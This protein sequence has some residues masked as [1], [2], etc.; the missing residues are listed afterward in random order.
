VAE[1]GPRRLSLILVVLLSASLLVALPL[2]PASI[3]GTVSDQTGAVITGATMTV[4]NTAGLK[5]ST[6]SDAQGNY[7]IK[8]LPA[9][10]YSLSASAPGFKAFRSDNLILTLA[11]DLTLDVSLEPAGESTTVTVEEH[12]AEV[13]TET[14]EVSGTITQKELVTLGLNGRNFTQLITLTPGVSNQTGQDEAKVGVQ[15]SAKYSVNGGRVEYNSFNLDGSDILNPNITASRGEAPLIVYP[16]L[17]ALSEVKV[18][19]SNYGAMYGRT[20]SGTVLATTKSGSKDFHGNL[21]EFVRNEVFNA[22]NYFNAPGVNPIYRRNDFG[23]TLGG[24]FYIPQLYGRDKSKT[25]FF[26]SEEFRYEKSPPDNAQTFNRAVPS[27]AERAGIFNDVCP[28]SGPI[29]GSGGFLFKRNAY[30][31]CPATQ[32]PPTLNGQATGYPGNIVPV[33]S[34]ATAMLNTGL[35]PL[36]NSTSGC[37]S[38]IGSCYVNS[39]ST[40]TYWHEN[41]FR[42]DQEITQNVKV[43]FRFVND[44]WSTTTVLPQWQPQSLTNSFPTVENSFSGPGISMAAQLSWAISPSMLNDLSLSY[45]SERITLRDVPGPGVTSL[46]R[47]SILDE[48]CTAPDPTTG[49]TTCP[50]GVLFNN[51]FGGKI[52][53]IV[54]GGNNA[55]YGG[56]GFNVDTSY[57]PWNYTNPTYQLRDSFSKAI[58][59]HTLQAG[60]QVFLGQLNELSAATGANTGDIQGIL[61]YSNINSPFTTGNAFADFLIGPTNSQGHTQDHSGIQYFAQDSTQLKY[62]NRYTV[63][64]PYV[65]DDWRATPR[66]TVNLGLRLSLFG[67]WHEKYNNAYN[68]SPQAYSQALASQVLV[69]PLV[70][71]L[72][73]SSTLQNIPLNLNKL[74]PRITNGLVRCGVGGIPSGC[75]RGHLFNPAPRIGFAWDPTGSGSTSIRAGYGIFFEHGTSY[76]ANTGSLIGSAPLVLTMTQNHPFTL[77]CI[78]GGRGQTGCAAGGAFPL[79]VVEI[80]SQATWPYVQQWSLSVE[81]QISRTFVGTIAYVGSKGTH[82]STELQAN[83]LIPL[84]AS[85]NPFGANQPITF[86]TCNSYN[87]G[88]FQVGNTTVVNTQ[89]AFINLLAACYGVA[90]TKVQ[91]DPNALR[92]YAPGF[93]QIYSIQNIADST[94]NALQAA[95]RSTRGPVNLILAYTYGHSIDDSSDRA[96]STFV[97][98][99]DLSS[100]RASSNFDQRH[101]LNIG[102]VIPEPFQLIARFYNSIFYQGPCPDCQYDPEPDIQAQASGSSGGIGDPHMPQVSDNEGVPVNKGASVSQDSGNHSSGPSLLREIFS[103]WEFSGIT[104]FQSG[105]PFSVINGGGSS[106]ISVLDNAGVAN[107]LGAGSYPNVVGSP[108]AYPPDGATNPQSFGPILG[109][110]AAFAAPQG[111]TFGNAGRNFLNNPH[112]TNFDMSLLKDF[113]VFG[114]RS[115]QFRVEAFNVFNHT[116]F[117]IYDPLLG[118]T[119]SNTISCYGGPSVGYSAAGGGGT[120]CLTGSSFLHPVDAHRARTLQLGAKFTF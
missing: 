3:S 106:G 76:E 107:G 97:N 40:P 24:P 99:F 47:P 71:N 36:P 104:T 101:L 82:L 61:T 17:D 34:F 16:S 92:Q 110:P 89:P 63:V 114:E 68:W 43:M 1:V 111:L 102:Y 116:Q 64:E 50:M 30:P 108:S 42:I 8:D 57:M 117:R 103:G 84:A 58:R 88:S 67:V 25:Y 22:R 48:P 26:V 87:G 53:G 74:D 55:A 95:I 60:V 78:N 46:G 4:S 31:D 2:P 86:D 7:T 118:N 37:N 66:L 81:H 6:I 52:P 75:M 65:Q 19:T 41:L 90:G 115:L 18:L 94:Y 5:Q 20:A 100:N 39:V 62:Y 112:R 35:I 15:G 109:N 27:V 120:N 21:Y 85:Q 28:T 72:V 113:R 54:I 70:G 23:G 93:G 44:T 69:D 79:S 80:P 91:V 10:T 38:T 13:E 98:S 32:I 12:K 83:Q 29:A 105:T 49:Y 14:S 77:D 51:G 96:D 59:K 45:V 119:G 73:S 33:T 11:Q 56:S 9:G